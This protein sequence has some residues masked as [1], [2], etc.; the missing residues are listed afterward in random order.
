MSNPPSVS[1]AD[2]CS[3]FPRW[4]VLAF[5]VGTALLQAIYATSRRERYIKS[6]SKAENIHG[7]KHREEHDG[8]PAEK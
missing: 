2:R 4:G 8:Q 5:C 6:I 7:A 3:V 1:C